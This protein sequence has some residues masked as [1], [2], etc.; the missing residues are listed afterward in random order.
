MVILTQTSQGRIIE[1]SAEDADVAELLWS[2]ST[3]GYAVRR[4]TSG[5]PNY[6]HKI[7]A[8][9]MY[10]KPIPTGIV[11]DHKDGNKLNCHRMNLRMV[12]HQQNLWNTKPKK[13][14]RTGYKGVQKSS[15][16]AWWAAIKHN[17]TREYFG[18]YKT[19]LEA[20]QVYDEKAREYFG[21]YA[22]I[23]FPTTGKR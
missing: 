10:G 14:S 21:E 11:I 6:L 18:P 1:L 4:Y 3:S 17:G 16:Q 12:T 13:S 9:R 20:A 19:P 23:N 5:K 22:R 7:I 2:M 15:N 8:V